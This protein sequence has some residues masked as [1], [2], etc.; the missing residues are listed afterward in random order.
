MN[1]KFK[2]EFI[3]YFDN[4]DNN[5]KIY[6]F[7]LDKWNITYSPYTCICEMQ[8]NLIQVSPL[9]EWYENKICGLYLMISDDISNNIKIV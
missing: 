4:I 6:N 1:Y 9:I 7:K 2:H 5:K 3:N 8:Y